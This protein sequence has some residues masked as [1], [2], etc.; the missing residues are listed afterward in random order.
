MSNSRMKNTSNSTNISKKTQNLIRAAIFSVLLFVAGFLSGRFI[1]V[2]GL[3]NSIRSNVVITGDKDGDVEGI[4]FDL[5]WKVWN[6]MS[7]QYVDGKKVDPEKMFYGAIQ[8]MVNSFDDAATIFLDPDETKSFNEGNAGKL[9]EG[10]GAELGYE[11]GQIVVIAPLSGSPAQAAG[12]KAGDAILEIDGEEV[13]QSENIFDV[14]QKIRGEAGTKVTLRILH[15]GEGTA[16]DITITR[17]EITV[18]SIEVKKLENGNIMMIDVGRFTDSSLFEWQEA[19]DNAVEKVKGA[20]GLVLD[21]RGN[22]GGYFDA[23]VYAANDFLA[24]GK[25]V[26]KQEDKNSRQESFKVSRNGKLLDIPLVVLVDGGSA[27][28]SEILAGALQQNDRAIVIGEDT[29]GKGTAQSIVPFSDGSSLHVTTL[30]WLLPD[31]SWLN[32]DNTIKPDV[33]VEFSEDSFLKGIDDQLN[34]A[35]E[36]LK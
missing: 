31:G 18:P 36:E 23:A 29:Y 24:K 11:N 28:A 12:I 13:K 34:R 17:G 4:D 6:T 26:A 19:W 20:D 22:P 25:V 5:F 7:S 32:H 15:K 33:V 1:D 16:E 9:F 10:I 14:V 21:L 2:P 35:V 3:P 30:K 8:G 27:S